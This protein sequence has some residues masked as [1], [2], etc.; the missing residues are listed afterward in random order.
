MLTFD[1]L[2]GILMIKYMIFLRF[3]IGL[4]FGGGSDSSK[5]WR[6]VYAPPRGT[7]SYLVKSCKMKGSLARSWNTMTILQDFAR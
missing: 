7:D 1:E 6:S 5:F 3:R 2:I 4:F